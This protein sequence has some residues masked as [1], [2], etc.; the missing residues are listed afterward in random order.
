MVDHPTLQTLPKVS[1][2]VGR[3]R[4]LPTALAEEGPQPII[5]DG[6]THPLTSRRDN[7]RNRPTCD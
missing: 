6:L 7:Q 5:D 1:L 2:W 4:T 3:G